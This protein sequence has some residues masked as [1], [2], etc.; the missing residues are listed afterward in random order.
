M[1]PLPLTVATGVM[2][3]APPPQ[4]LSARAVAA[5]AA[6]PQ[7]AFNS[8]AK[9]R[10]DIGAPLRRPHIVNSNRTSGTR[11]YFGTIL[12]KPAVSSTR[13]GMLIEINFPRPRAGHERTP[14]SARLDC[15]DH[16]AYEIVRIV[17]AGFVVWR[18]R[19]ENRYRL[20]P[21]VH[22]APH[23]T[24]VRADIQRQPSGEPLQPHRRR[25]RAPGAD[26]RDVRRFRPA[27]CAYGKQRE[28]RRRLSFT[29]RSHLARNTGVRRGFRANYPV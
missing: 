10:P 13:Q 29:R 24:R 22:I 9:Q 27:A 4:A 8:N 25:L 18:G 26:D 1:A 11:R 2:E 3:L 12:T 28:A 14:L 20:S 7:K 5:I 17:N 19:I 16:A 23:M 6:R 15:C 21:I